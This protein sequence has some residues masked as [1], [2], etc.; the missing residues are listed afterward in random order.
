MTP[1]LG[2]HV[3]A[4][5]LLASILGCSK[6][7]A[8]AGINIT[9][10]FTAPLIYPVNYWVGVKLVG[11]SKG[12]DWSIHLDHAAML[13]LMRRSPLILVDLSIGGLVLG[14]PLAVAGYFLVLWLIRFS[15]KPVPTR[16]GD[17]CPR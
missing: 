15:R 11:L 13:A 2:A 3:I 4:C 17:H 12:T 14:I 6:I 9:N 8:I 16:S 1:F 5:I 10:V 7:A